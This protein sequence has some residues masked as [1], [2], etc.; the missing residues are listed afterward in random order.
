VQ[1]ISD[2]YA[3]EYLYAGDG[4]QQH[5]LNEQQ[6]QAVLQY[7]GGMPLALRVIRS[8]LRDESERPEV[9]RKI[10]TSLNDKEP[11]G[12]YSQD[13][14]LD[15]LQLSV[16]LL[17]SAD[18]G[19]WLDICMLFPTEEWIQ[20]E[21]VYGQECM[22]KLLRHNLIIK[23][24]GLWPHTMEIAVHHVLLTLAHSICQKSSGRYRVGDFTAATAAARFAAGEEVT[25]HDSPVLLIDDSQLLA[26]LN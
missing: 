16:D 11:V 18:L 3:K 21:W 23:Q 10:K 20:L 26:Q 17:P 15:R 5:D 1:Q 6:E 4:L 8:F 19:A 7:C 9:L 14:M 12:V 24:E 25:E 13:W 2:E 22:A